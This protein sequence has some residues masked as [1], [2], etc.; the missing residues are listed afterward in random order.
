MRPPIAPF[1]ALLAWA[2]FVPAAVAQD[3]E[4][5][6]TCPVMKGEP[7]DPERFVV[8]EGKKVYF[9]CNKCQGRFEN[10]PAAYLAMLPQFGGD[11]PAAPEWWW[12]LRLLGRLHPS[13]VHFPIALLLIVFVLELFRIRRK[14][15]G[16]EPVLVILLGLAAGSAVIAAGFGWMHA[17]NEA[18]LGEAAETLWVHRWVGVA[19]AGLSVAA[20]ALFLGR[21]RRAFVQAYRAA[22]VIAA[23]GVTISSHYGGMLVHGNDYLTSLWPGSSVERKPPVDPVEAPPP[24]KIA[25]NRDIRPIFSD[26]CFKCH[27]P[28]ENNREADLRLDRAEGTIETVVPGNPDKSK[29]Y[30]RISSTDPDFMMPPPDSGKKLTQS[31]IASFKL[32]IDQGAEWKPH[33][34]FTPLVAP[35]L[36]PL[37]DSG[38]VRNEIDRFVR[39]RHERERLSPAPEADRPTLIRRVSFDLT[40][41]PP[42]PEEVD[43]FVDDERPD[44]YE[45]LVDR[46][47]ESPG[48][49][50]HMARFWLDGVRY[51]DTHG[52]HFDN[53]REI[54]PYRDWV[55][56]AYNENMPFDRFITEQLAGDLL[57]NRTLDQQIASGFNRCNI[58]TNEGGSINEEVYVR[59][60]TDRVD[61]SATVFLGLTLACSRCHEHKYDPFT[62][63]DYY[64][65]F[66][67][68]N[69]LDGPVMDGNSKRHAPVVKVPSD[70]QSAKLSQLRGR[71]KEIESLMNGP[72]AE[73]DAAQAKW[74]ALCRTQ[75]DTD[76]TVLDL[77][78]YESIGGATMKKQPDKSIL[79]SG[80]NPEKD[81]Y[82]LVAR[83]NGDGIRAIRLDALTHASIPFGGTGRAKNA[84]FVLSEF[85]ADVMPVGKPAEAE[86]VKFT[87]A[88][89]D[90]SQNRYPISLAIDGKDSTGWSIAG[91]SR[92]E[93]RT[94]IFVPEQPL[95][96]EGGTELRM[97]MRFRF[98]TSHT[99]GRF[100]I[101]V[102]TDEEAAA[103]ARSS[104]LGPWSSAGAF[105]A[106][107]ARTAYDTDFGPEE[108]GGKKVT[109]AP[110]PKFADGK[111]HKLKGAISA[112]YLQRAIQAPKARAMT[113]SL[114]SDDAIKVWLN[115]RPVLERYVGRGVAPDQEILTLQLEEGSN[116]LLMKIINFGGGY[117]F[118]FKVIGEAFWD[119]PLD[120]AEIVAVPADK[121]TDAQKKR[122]RSTYRSRHW[123]EWKALEKE[124][125]KVRVEETKINAKIPTSLIYKERA[126][127]RDAFILKRGEYDQR[128]DKVARNTPEVLPPMADDLPRNRLGLARGL[129]DPSHPLTARVAVNRFWQQCFGI[130][131]VRTSEDLGSQ[132]E[133]PSHPKLLDF[134]AA[135]FIADGWDVKKTMKRIVMSAT[136]R[137]SSRMTPEL[138]R[139]DPENR[140]LA[141]GPRFRLDAEMLRDQALAVGGLLVEKIGG[142]S[143]KPSQPA[144]LWKAVAYVGSDTMNFKKDT[145]PDKVYRRS[146]YTFWKRTSVAPQMGMFDAP[147]R[148]SC[149]VR[150][151]RTNTPLQ[152]LL[153]MNDPQYVEAARALAELALKEGG[154]TPEER[155]AWMFKR[156]TARAPD[157]EDLA[158]LVGFYVDQKA[159]Y[160]ADPEAAKKLIA[161]GES[162]PDASLDPVEL[163]TWTMVANLI[164]NLDEVITK[165]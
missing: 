90:L 49:G 87:A 6:S 48:Y 79:L 68:F 61:T 163:A 89:A 77:V 70:V 38:W 148:E 1:L 106:K 158:D 105:A 142:P 134:L 162:K 125:S 124:L 40:G 78:R 159:G 114:G 5:N 72:V 156:A 12:G 22:L 154:T 131:I 3:A 82:E 91:M 98:G 153:L 8:H 92:R 69:S 54:W 42:T 140:L 120:V 117:G 157:A 13:V 44:A 28:S 60:V 9:C 118:Y 34:S 111:I 143:V 74:E 21:K 41:L 26:N 122:L 104:V 115:G 32:W 18:F 132:G 100:R 129:V 101:L 17:E 73:L 29:L 71:I 24:R 152:A 46:L 97:R 20:W 45:K 14:R 123:P 126:K 86:T 145:G 109:W 164:L 99:I 55:I 2:L 139:R 66:A 135:Q 110:R 27:G 141:R 80:S 133:P 81:M 75:N 25:F 50:E 76:W 52:L 88:Y 103:G 147:S 121:R 150:R 136:Y 112:T 65:L 43:A 151:E 83:T 19:V 107:D 63:K 56:G 116:E 58:T 138:K 130:G 160:T 108:A 53:Y 4:A 95:G 84:N 128:G 57:P 113:L 161:I 59:N 31:E 10:D 7:I 146:L 23:A 62:Q 94:A 35:D 15:P 96:F 137:Q 149:V 30:R 93:P 16:A 102:T 64:Q 47:L 37:R 155:A 36:P 39:A 51:A 127:P 33:W 67:F 11:A 119:P 165:S 85:Q 144:G